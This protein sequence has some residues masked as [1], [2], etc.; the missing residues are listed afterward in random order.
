MSEREIKFRAWD[1]E[2]KKWVGKDKHEYLCVCEDVVVLVKYG[3]NSQGGYNPVSCRQLSW[4]ETK[5]LEIIQF[6]NIK[7]LWEDDI[8]AFSVFDHDGNDIQYKGVI[9]FAE[10]QW[11]IW[12]SNNSEYYGDN[13]AFELYWVHMQ[14]DELRAI[15]NIHNNPELLEAT[16]DD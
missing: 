1:K 4:E 6:T 15:G 7:D 12:K 2:N 8:V 5:N 13:G 11:Q 14:D 10:G 9:K 16:N 3:P